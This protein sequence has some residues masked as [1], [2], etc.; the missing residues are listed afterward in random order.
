MLHPI[1]EKRYR[2]DIIRDSAWNVDPRSVLLSER[3]DLLY[4]AAESGLT[5][6]ESPGTG[7]WAAPDDLVWDA[8]PLASTLRG[9]R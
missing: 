4:D 3:I 2:H 9:D 7:G 5:D 8:C 1:T 6:P